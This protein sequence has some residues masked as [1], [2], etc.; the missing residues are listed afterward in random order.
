MALL[1]NLW[2]K[3]QEDVIFYVE[4]Q[5]IFS[6]AIWQI[7]IVCCIIKFWSTQRQFIVEYLKTPSRASFKVT[8]GPVFRGSH[9]T[10]VIV[11]YLNKTSI[12]LPLR[13]ISD[14]QKIAVPWLSPCHL[15]GVFKVQWLKIPVSE[16]CKY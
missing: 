5:T 1:I 15:W 7:L 10:H 6:T 8:G 14:W 16:E 2:K 12:H 13:H 11:D 3:T 9:M 4:M